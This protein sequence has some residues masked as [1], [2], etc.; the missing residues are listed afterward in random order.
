LPPSL[1]NDALTYDRGSEK[2]TAMMIKR[3]SAARRDGQKF[4][5]E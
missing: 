5:R 1:F 4:T 2:N 3:Y